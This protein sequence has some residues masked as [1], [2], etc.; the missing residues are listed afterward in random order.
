MP[1]VLLDPFELK[2]T[3][4][5]IE[6][7][8]AATI[9]KRKSL[10]S[11]PEGHVTRKIWW[12]YTW[13]IK[14]IL[15]ITIPNPKSYRRLYPLT[16]LMCIIFIGFNSYMIVW[17]VTVMGKCFQISYHIHNVHGLFNLLHRFYILGARISNG[18]DLSSRWW[19]H[20]RGHLECA[21]GEKR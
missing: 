5:N 10:W 8:A 1:I 21:D 13:P 4:A 2:K 15:T 17:M 12:L 11:I 14:C 3:E 7:A 9:K 16:F 18:T 19:M 6:F 20:A